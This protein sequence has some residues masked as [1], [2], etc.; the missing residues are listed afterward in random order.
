MNLTRVKGGELFAEMPFNV[1]GSFI[2]V[3]DYWKE[4]AKIEDNP[5][6]ATAAQS[7]LEEI[8]HAKELFEPFDDITV[9]E[10]YGSEIQRLFNPMFPD[11]LQENEIKGLSLPF[12]MFFFNPTKR[13]Q[14]ILDR[15]G[16]DFDI[17]MR[18]VNAKNMYIMGCVSIINS[19]YG[20]GIPFKRPFFLTIPDKK[21]GIERYYRAFINAD[22][23]KLTPTERSPHLT[24]E[25]IR[26]LIDNYS[27]LELWKEKIP[28]NS[29]N[30]EGF[31]MITLFDVTEDE[32]LSS[33][34][35]ILLEPDAMHDS[36]K[37]AELEQKLRSYFQM[38]DIRLG[39]ATLERETGKVRIMKDASTCE[40][41]DDLTLDIDDCLCATSMRHLLVN[42]EPV[43]VSNLTD[44][45]SNGFDNPLMDRMRAKGVKSFIICPLE[46]GEETIG[47][48]ELSST[49]PYA[50]NSV[51]A[52]NLKDIIPL[53]TIAMQRAATER[54]TILEA[55]IQ[56]E[57]T[58]IH[59]SVSWRFF[60]VAEN[61]LANRR[62]GRPDNIEDVV[63]NDVVPMYGQFDIRG[64]ST[65][66]NLAIQADL[67][68]QLNAAEKV[69]SIAEMISRLPLYDHLK[70]R[71]Q[72]WRA[73][74]ETGIESG[75]E[76]KILDFLKAEIYPAFNYM[77]EAHPTLK[78]EVD[79]YMELVDPELDV[80]YDE[81]KK[82]EDSVTAINDAIADVVESHQAKAQVMHPHYFEKYKTDGIE[83]NAY[84]GDSISPNQK[85]DEVFEHNLRLW[86]LMLS[87]A[88]EMR[89][90][91]LK[92]SLE[93]KLDIAS[94]ILV[95]KSPLSIKF[96]MDEMKFDVDGTYNIRYEII[97]KRIDKAY[98]RGTDE[99]LTQPGKL[100]IVYSHDDE[101]QEYERYLEYMK[102]MN[103][104][105]GEI[106]HVEL[107]SL[108][109]AVGLRA[110]R[111]DF[112]YDLVLEDDEAAKLEKIINEG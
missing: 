55:I 80:I 60:E 64:S 46:Y 65:A 45:K 41:V 34:K 51:V 50:L 91:D 8:S 90:H 112:N 11:M 20:H 38:S 93:T 47:F 105:K 81:R 29:Y 31:S 79:K 40:S 94:L 18:D 85:F 23:V 53:Y 16:D 52:A 58:S 10:K 57:F 83:Y 88:V 12:K 30:F 3:I 24:E 98:V 63:F 92:P 27:N 96:R 78:V 72:K 74:L 66:R 73:N 69:M 102:S 107:E 25:D 22:Y 17:L 28:P 100:A 104:V 99:R 2:P 70:F 54:E 37:L 39:F 36:S 56:E 9:I 19:V 44:T 67:V 49:T 84:I 35:N 106:E 33:M 68:R 89:I 62:L 108:Q 71:I 15:A 61:I 111:V 6:V 48:L 5:A 103:M 43:I 14:G 59:P 95:H 87:H 109:G 32:S 75:D 82:Y 77:K 26:E 7:I 1:R 42:R 21:L 13:L 110:L 86:Q 97:K 101:A 4:M 76:V